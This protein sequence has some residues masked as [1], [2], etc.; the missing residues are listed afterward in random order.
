MK[1]VIKQKTQLLQNNYSS[2]VDTAVVVCPKR[3]FVMAGV[4]VE[5]AATK[6]VAVSIKE[7]KQSIRYFK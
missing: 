1:F 3:K 5:M 4:S 6:L 2:N 7:Y